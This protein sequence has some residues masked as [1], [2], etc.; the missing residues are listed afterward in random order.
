MTQTN[1]ISIDLSTYSKFCRIIMM[2][3]LTDVVNLQYLRQRDKERG[4]LGK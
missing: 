2:I 3:K 4:R 1:G